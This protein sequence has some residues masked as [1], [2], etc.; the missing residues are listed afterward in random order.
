MIL[1]DPAH[2][3]AVHHA[4]IFSGGEPPSWT[5]WMSKITWHEWGVDW[6]P[7]EVEGEKH[8][9]VVELNHNMTFLGKVHLFQLKV[10]HIVCNSG[11]K[12]E[13]K[14]NLGPV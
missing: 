8:R 4:P 11:L 7:N 6:R 13:K 5:E 9:A 1:L 12:S 3:P 10:R 2:L 14:C